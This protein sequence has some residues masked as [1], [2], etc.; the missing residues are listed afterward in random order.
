MA[1]RKEIQT[2]A[3]GRFME[4]VGPQQGREEGENVDMWNRVAECQWSQTLVFRD[5][6]QSLSDTCVGCE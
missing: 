2:Q 3:K 6:E 5:R 4:N 1:G